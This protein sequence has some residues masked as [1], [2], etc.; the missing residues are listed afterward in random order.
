MQQVRIFASFVAL[1][2]LGV[3]AVPAWA[4]NVPVADASSFGS[5]TGQLGSSTLSIPSS[6]PCVLATVNCSTVIYT[7]DISSQT[8]VSGSAYTYVYA[9]KLDSATNYSC[10]G[11]GVACINPVTSSNTSLTLHTLTIGSTGFDLALNYG[12]VG[13]CT[14]GLAACGQ[15]L[16]HRTEL[17]SVAGRHPAARYRNSA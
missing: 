2:M 7:V 4:G 3:L 5:I 13:T 14:G 16:L 8:F 17:T 1:L 9:I 6:N 10:T 11:N 15:N 12:T